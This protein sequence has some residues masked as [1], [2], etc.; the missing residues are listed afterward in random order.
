M[1]TLLLLALVIGQA[2]DADFPRAIV[3]WVPEPANPVFQGAGGDAW[4]R[5]EG[6]SRSV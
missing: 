5:R 2:P 1:Q 3:S 6:R 4:D